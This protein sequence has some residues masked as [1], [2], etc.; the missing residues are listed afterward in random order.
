ME[1]ENAIKEFITLI[2]NNNLKTI[3][4]RDEDN[5]YH[6]Q[7]TQTIFNG[8][9]RVYGWGSFVNSSTEL[10]ISAI[11]KHIKRIEKGETK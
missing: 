3:I 4:V 8:D 7:T 5:S 11:A 9:V 2:N 1:I 10:S 6:T